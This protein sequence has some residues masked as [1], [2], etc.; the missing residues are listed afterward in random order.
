LK[1]SITILRRTEELPESELIK[2][3]IRNNRKAQKMLYY[4]YCNA[5]YSTAYRIV[6]DREEA[7]DVLQDAFIQIFRDLKNFR[8][9]S[10]VGSWMKT[11]VIRAALKRLNNRLEFQTVDD[12]S[13]YLLPEHFIHMDAE[14][15]EK[16]IL[17]LPDGYRT[18]FLLVEV[19]G[20]NHKEV[21]RMLDITES[22]SKSQLSRAKKAL[23]EIITGKSEE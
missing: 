21:A 9:E 16:A 11:I 22:T 1:N 6:N 12:P 17:S 19:E 5:M 18:V 8:N 2:R 20:Y 15:L 10:T 7:N 4:K 13:I 3:S 14:Y 23:R